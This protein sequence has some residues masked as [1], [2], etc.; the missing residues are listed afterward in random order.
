MNLLTSVIVRV[1]QTTETWN[2]KK[3]KKTGLC[4][5]LFT[6]AARLVV[7][8]KSACQKVRELIVVEGARLI[9]ALESEIE[10][11]KTMSNLKGKVKEIQ[12]IVKLAS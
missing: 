12:A 8:D 1:V 4:V 6:K 10:K 7:K 11:D 5:N 9:T 2:N 3:V